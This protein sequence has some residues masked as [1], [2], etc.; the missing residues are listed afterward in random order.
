MPWQFNDLE[1]RRDARS[2]R[3][4]EEK[5][6][7]D[8]TK[9]QITRKELLA[10][11][12]LKWR[13]MTEEDA[14]EIWNDLVPGLD[15]AAPRDCGAVARPKGMSFAY[16]QETTLPSFEMPSFEPSSF[17]CESFEMRSGMFDAQAFLSKPGSSS[18]MSRSV[19]PGKNG[20]RPG[21]PDGAAKKT[22]EEEDEEWSRLVQQKQTAKAANRAAKAAFAIYRRI[23]RTEVRVIF[24]IQNSCIF[25]IP[26]A[27]LL[28]LDLAHECRRVLW[29]VRAASS[30]G[31]FPVAAEKLQNPEWGPECEYDGALRFA[32]A[33]LKIL[34]L[35]PEELTQFRLTQQDI[36]APFGLD[37]EDKAMVY[38]SEDDPD[39]IWRQP[40]SKRS[41]R[42]KQLRQYVGFVVIPLQ[43]VYDLNFF[44][45]RAQHA[46]SK[47]YPHHAAAG[48]Q[49]QKFKVTIPIRRQLRGRY[50]NA[51][52]L[53][54]SEFFWNDAG[55]EPAT[56]SG[57]E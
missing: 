24:E 16:D 20:L 37:A 35:L 36:A 34:D 55:R 43:Q 8:N 50:F 4:R 42:S 15:L 22:A 27:E 3:D 54:L 52:V 12:Q 31:A 14:D 10:Q 26:E 25:E 30:R 47:W 23:D 56:S 19:E 18:T 5:E 29:H 57:G 41:K 6:E 7:Y 51:N 48:L 32:R 53:L 2:I 13:F 45:Y 17:E 49:S 11:L 33:D 38:I 39:A 21:L 46:F 9:S 1:E 40:G 28:Q 44:S